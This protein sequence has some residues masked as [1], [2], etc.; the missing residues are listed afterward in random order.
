[1]TRI[2][3]LLTNVGIDEDM[4]RFTRQA[5]HENIGPAITGEVMGE[6]EKVVGISPGR[7]VGRLGWAGG[8]VGGRREVDPGDEVGAKPDAVAGRNIGMAIT[9]EVCDGAALGHKPLSEGPFGECHVVGDGER[10]R[11]HE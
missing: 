11:A 6:G 4:R 2:T 3:L 7:I 9:V 10:C 8:I 1:M 5:V